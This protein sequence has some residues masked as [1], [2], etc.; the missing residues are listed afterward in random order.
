MFTKKYAP[1]I[2]LCRCS[3]R[4]EFWCVLFE[5][6]T[7]SFFGVD[8]HPRRATFSTEEEVTK[9]V[10]SVETIPGLEGT[11]EVS[12]TRPLLYLEK[13]VTLFG[14]PGLIPF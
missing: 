2:L 5:Y 7:I 1:P 10:G 6:N 13:Y 4:E 14:W 8:K 12:F 11:I 9:I 3:F